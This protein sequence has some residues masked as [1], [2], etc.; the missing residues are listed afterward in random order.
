MDD[1]LTTCL[2][3]IIRFVN[4]KKDHIP[5]ITT[6]D[7]NPFPFQVRIYNNIY[8]THCSYGF[9][10]YGFIKIFHIYNRLLFLLQRILGVQC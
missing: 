9:I 4:D 1:Q 7:A 10:S 2:L 8:F 6:S 3:K 5:P